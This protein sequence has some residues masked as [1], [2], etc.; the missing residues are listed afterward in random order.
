MLDMC[1][2]MEAV[3]SPD[4]TFLNYVNPM[5]MNTWAVTKAT[6]VKT[7]GL[8]HSVQGTAEQL[9]KDIHVPIDEINYLCA[10]INHMAFYLK[11]ERDGVD[12][13]PLIRDVVTEGRIPDWNR[14]RYEMLTRL[15]L[16]RHREQRAFCGVHALLYPPGSTGPHRKIQCADS[17][18]IS[19]AAKTRSR[20]GTR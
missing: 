17:T 20:A 2:D 18:S 19:G 6:K 8:C 7:V 5:C 12:L 14:V 1:R 13:Y 3:A 4:L 16:L 10:G 9:A 11:F 15:G